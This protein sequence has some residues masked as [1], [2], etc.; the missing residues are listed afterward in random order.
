MLFFLTVVLV[1][2]LVAFLI[3]NVHLY[4]ANNDLRTKLDELQT[5]LDDSQRELDNLQNELD[6]LQRELSDSL[7]RLQGWRIFPNSL[8]MMIETDKSTALVGEPLM[9]N[10][11][12]RNLGTEDFEYWITSSN[13]PDTKLSVTRIGGGE[14]YYIHYRWMDLF[15]GWLDLPVL[16]PRKIPSMKIKS[17]IHYAKF[18]EVGEYNVTASFYGLEKVDS[19][20]F[21]SFDISMTV[22]ATNADDIEITL[23]D[24]IG[25]VNKGQPR[26]CSLIRSESLKHPIWVLGFDSRDNF[27]VD[28]LQGDISS[29]PPSLWD[30]AILEMLEYQST[31]RYMHV[32]IGATTDF[33]HTMI[34][35]LEG[36]GAKNVKIL[37]TVI[38]RDTVSAYIPCDYNKIIGMAGLWFVDN[39]EGLRSISDDC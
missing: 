39:F 6:N 38:A 7:G 11:S 2:T 10:V 26:R 30:M 22:N 34:S 32:I 25:I 9:I 4:T 33:T 29:I 8:L 16:T 28:A 37:G 27:A 24:A 36:F 35:E 1:G 31:D 23:E 18:L 3:M 15:S 17:E 13:A 20:S 5:R 12:I 14:S 19:P 21:F